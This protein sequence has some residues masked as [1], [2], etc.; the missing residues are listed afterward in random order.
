[1]EAKTNALEIIVL[2][3]CAMILVGYIVYNYGHPSHGLVRVYDCS[4]SE[5]SPDYPPEVK[6]EC[7]KARRQ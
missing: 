6:Q 4:I 1:M 7:R 2:I 3:I 5:I